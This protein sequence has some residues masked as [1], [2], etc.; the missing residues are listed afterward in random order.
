METRL[1]GYLEHFEEDSFLLN[2]MSKLNLINNRDYIT[3]RK[4]GLTIEEA[5][6]ALALVRDFS[7]Y[8][9]EIIITRIEANSLAN[10][11]IV[12]KRWKIVT[13]DP[14]IKKHPKLV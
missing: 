5:H 12:I 10:T 3:A 8:S 6:K 9:L 2:K 13:N 7:K 4:C 1:F 11:S 14:E